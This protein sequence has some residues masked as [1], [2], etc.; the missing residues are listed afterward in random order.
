MTHETI[1]IVAGVLAL[2][3]YIPYIYSI[4][5]GQTRPNQAS[6]IIW[7]VVGGLLAVSYFAEGDAN[8]IWLPI[9]YFVGPLLV[10]ILSLRYG[11]MEWSKLDKACLVAA[12]ISIIPWLL[13]KDATITLL[14]NVLIDSTGAIPTIVKTYKE[15]ETED[16][17]AWL[18][19]FAANTIQLF[20]INSW[21]LSVIYPVYLFLLAG[22]IVLLIVKD[23]LTSTSR[24]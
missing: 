3:G 10:A 7:T 14:M 17:T 6:W 2:A 15:P 8:A 22:S 20:A 21:N 18:I 5:K 16:F 13:V 12:M 23:K 9:G 11:Y 19:F 1:G 24:I 4:F